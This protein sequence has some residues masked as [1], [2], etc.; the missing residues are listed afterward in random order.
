MRITAELLQQ[1]AEQRTNPCEMRELVLRGYGIMVLENLAAIPAGIVAWDLS[2]N[3]LQQFNNLPTK[4]VAD[5]ESL[6][7]ISNQIS[8]IQLKPKQLPKLQLCN[9]EKNQISS[10][11]IIAN[12]AQASPNLEFLS[13]QDNP[14]CLQPHYRLFVI[15]IFDRYFREQYDSS[16]ETTSSSLQ[17]QL[18]VLDYQ[19]ITQAERTKAQKW[20]R[21]KTGVAAL[22]QIAQQ[23]DSDQGVKT[24]T[25][26]ESID[27]EEAFSKPKV[28]LSMEQKSLLQELLEHADS[29]AQI[30]EIQTYLS[31]ATDSDT[32]TSYLNKSLQAAK[33]EE[34]SAKRVRLG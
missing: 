32:V 7:V 17:P 19:R 8:S 1:I 25:P 9:F 21:S 28:E 13:L 33:G 24:F 5:L 11:S 29:E 12:L 3:R 30:L 27:D 4:T 31:Q 22:D 26:G 20:S 16:K 14:V 6:L 15:F 34:P 10:F 2:H 18:R 23:K